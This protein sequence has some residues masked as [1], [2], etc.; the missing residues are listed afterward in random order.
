MKEWC[1]VSLPKPNYRS[2]AMWC[3]LLPVLPADSSAAGPEPMRLV[4][5]PTA[6]LIDKGRYGIG[7]RLFPDGGMMGR[8]NAGVLK[9]LG[10]GISFGGEK[11]IGDRSIDWYPRVEVAIRYR[12]IEEN[13][14]LPGIIV[15]YETQGFGRHLK[16]R[17][18]IKSKGVFAA[19]SKN[20]LSAF[21]QF[22]VH[23]GLNM[24]RE[25]R[26]EDGD[27]SA[28]FGVDK[29]INED[30]SLVAEWDLGLND[31]TTNSLGTGD[32]YLNAGARLSLAPELV[33]AFY[34]K[35]LA[36]NGLDE[37]NPSR[38][39]AVLYTEEF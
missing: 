16:D 8:I 1:T 20:Y 36:G 33:I 31:N 15:G 10:I 6:G 2:I 14:A 9:R 17:Y 19:A 18:Q 23:G 4:D 7:L 13:R 32:G 24:S 3:A 28:W 5:S 12:L 38:E 25:D 30:L 22:G 39:L 37:P 27:L 35:N 26:D 34:V 11:V 21:G 29:Y